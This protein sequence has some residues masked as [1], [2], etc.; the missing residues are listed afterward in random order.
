MKCI[1][2]Q[3][4]EMK[5]PQDNLYAVI[6]EYMPPVENGDIILFTS[7]VVSIHQGRCYKKRETDKI[8]LAMAEADAYTYTVSPQKKRL[9]A[10][11][12]HAIS[13]Y[14][15]IDPYHDYFITLPHEPNKEAERLGRYIK[16]K[17]Q[18]EKLGVIITDSHSMPLRRGV[19]CYAVGFAGISP[20]LDRGQR[21]Y[22]K[23]TS[24][25]VDVLAGYGGIYLGE[26]AQSSQL[27]PIV[28]MR[29]VENVDYTDTDLS[30]VFFVD[31]ENDLYSPLL[32]DFKKK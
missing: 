24:N 8:D 22:T 14:A 23:W 27:T 18:I 7:K 1:P 12:H 13:L 3:T 30:D 32:K 9:V 28:I 26:S 17:F 25:V 6:D 2:I 21:N 11:K 19:L 20:L 31:G 16:K 4:R 29:G 15:G 5:P 10:V